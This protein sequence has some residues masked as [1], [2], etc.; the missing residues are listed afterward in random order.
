MI[1]QRRNPT[2]GIEL[3]P[4]HVVLLCS[5]FLL[6]CLGCDSS[7]STSSKPVNSTPPIA[8][9]KLLRAELPSPRDNSFV[10]SEACRE[11]H[12]QI[13]ELYDQHPMGQSISSIVDLKPIEQPTD[14]WLE[15]PG[16]DKYRVSLKADA[17]GRITE[18]THQQTHFDAQGNSLAEI[19]EPIAYAIGSG[20]KGRAYFIFKD[21][22]LFQSPVGWYTANQRWDLSPGYSPQRHPGFQRRI[23]NSCLYCHAGQMDSLSEDHYKGEV[24]HETA[25]GCE[26]C[27]GPGT[28][29]IEFQRQKKSAAVANSPPETKAIDPICNPAK[30]AAAP[31]E[32]VCN[33]CHLQAEKVIP[34]FGRSFFDFRPGDRLE[35]VFVV[36]SS[37]TRQ[38]SRGNFRA[39]SH[40]EQMRESRC[41]IGSE[42]A[43]SCTSCHD[44]HQVPAP[45]ERVDHFRQSCLACHSNKG[46][47]VASDERNK[48][49]FFDSCIACHMPR[50]EIANVPHT[51]QTDHRILRQKDAAVESPRAEAWSVVD[52][53]Q[54]RVPAWEIARARGLA[55]IVL[56]VKSR[57]LG[58]AIRAREYLTPD[59]IEADDTR[60][61]LAALANDADSLS[62]IASAYWIEGRYADARPFWEKALE[63]VP[64]YET[65]L[66]GLIQLDLDANDLPA[67]LRSAKRLV[68]IAPTEAAHWIQLSDLQWKANLKPDSI[69]SAEQA[70][71]LDPDIDETRKWLEKAK[72]N[73]DASSP[74]QP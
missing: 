57:D 28:Q 27:H 73:L 74:S 40:V 68:E 52:N 38:E 56:A 65:A 43:L 8:A 53:A 39:V 6:T 21:Q 35:D 49:P 62:G 41:Y 16:P 19:I 51:A 5:G 10:G 17:S 72:K 24:F 33:Q 36:F 44:P 37:S 64:N 14:Q 3:K 12:A 9:N 66:S 20:Q 60:I 50:S 30:L 55:M 67:A 70:L 1:F 34:R 61:V 63:V 26:R 13:A 4:L 15:V 46:C 58:M 69:Q 71:R 29:H 7:P 25:I 48:E 59:E 2:T 31:R 47:S 45:A 22:M 32:D 54:E 11:C 23:D 18:L 42:Q